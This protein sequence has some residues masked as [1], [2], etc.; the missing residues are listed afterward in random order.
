MTGKYQAVNPWKPHKRGS[1]VHE[2]IIEIDGRIEEMGSRPS[3]SRWVM[4]ITVVILLIGAGFMFY[5]A[6]GNG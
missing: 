2:L 6:Y 5:V 3:F 4:K 1:T